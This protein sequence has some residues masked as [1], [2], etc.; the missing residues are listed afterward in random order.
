MA[1]E[2][3]PFGEG[4]EEAIPSA[5][6]KWTEVGQQFK[7]I[8]MDMEERESTINGEMQKI[9]TFEDENG[10]EFRVGSRGKVFD[11]ALKKV[12]KGQWVGFLYAKDIPSKKKGY[13]AFKNIKVYPGQVDPG[14]ATSIP[15]DASSSD[16]APFEE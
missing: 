12:V 9:Y 1:D 16:S 11:S 3:N 14:Y 8:F 5:F 13:S 15:E 6:I 10:D 7:G 2:K 4:F